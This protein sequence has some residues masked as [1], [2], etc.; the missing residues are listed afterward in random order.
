MDVLVCFDNS[1]NVKIKGMAM[2]FN[3]LNRYKLMNSVDLCVWLGI[4]TR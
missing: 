1:E 2:Y 3:Y 4:G